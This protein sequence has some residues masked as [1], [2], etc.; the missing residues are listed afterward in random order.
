MTKKKKRPRK[1]TSAN[2]TTSYGSLDTW[3]LRVRR[4]ILFAFAEIELA[5][6]PGPTP[7]DVVRAL[8]PILYPLPF[9]IAVLVLIGK[10]GWGDRGRVQIV[11]IAVGDV[12]GLEIDEKKAIDVVDTSDAH[13]VFG[14][15]NHVGRD[16][17]PSRED[18][19]GFRSLKKSFDDREIAFDEF[20][21]ARGGLAYSVRDRTKI[22]LE[23]TP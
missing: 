20:A 11:E 5:A 10:S 13:T 23:V 18:I 22:E 21:I 1:R 19:S 3:D 14:A 17:I 6:L 4:A 15:H 12:N 8:T 7:A 2:L 16:A 9:E